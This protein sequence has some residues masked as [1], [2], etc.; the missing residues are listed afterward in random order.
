M[1]V[2]FYSR[3]VIVGD[4]RIVSAEHLARHTADIRAWMAGGVDADRAADVLAGQI[5][6]LIKGEPL[7]LPAA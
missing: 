7:A 3:I 1:L 4:P 2:V 6:S 5:E